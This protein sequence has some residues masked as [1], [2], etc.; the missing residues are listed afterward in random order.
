V[1]TACQADAD[2]VAFAQCMQT[3]MCSSKP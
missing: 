1:Q 3:S 2:C